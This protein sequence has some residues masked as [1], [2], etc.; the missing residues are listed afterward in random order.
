[1]QNVINKSGVKVKKL[2]TDKNVDL[3]MWP[4]SNLGGRLTGPIL[5]PLATG[6]QQAPAEHRQDRGAAVSHRST[7][8]SASEVTSASRHRRSHANF[9]RQRPRYTHRL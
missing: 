3:K 1:M 5:H 6:L 7:F 8:L 2:L 4:W 9:C